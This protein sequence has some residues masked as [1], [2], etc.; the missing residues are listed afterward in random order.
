[1]VAHPCAPPCGLYL[2]ALPL[3][4]GAP[5][6][7]KARAKA[8]QKAASGERQS[9]LMVEQSSVAVPKSFN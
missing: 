4:Y 3:R 1:N 8:K 6:K 9:E 5:E 2:P 7:L